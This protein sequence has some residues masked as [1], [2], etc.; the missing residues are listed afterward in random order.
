MNRAGI[1]TEGRVFLVMERL[2]ART[3]RRILDRARKRQLDFLNAL[4][5][6]L[7]IA[8]AIGA[9]HEAGCGTGT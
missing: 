9:A 2:R 4:H 1:T 6:M 5:L 7:Q 3:L 8:E